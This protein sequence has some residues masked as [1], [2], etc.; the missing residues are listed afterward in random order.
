MNTSWQDIDGWIKLGGIPVVTLFTTAL[1]LYGARRSE[2]KL[3]FG[4]L[5]VAGVLMLLSDLY[6]LVMRLRYEFYHHAMPHNRFFAVLWPVTN[7]CWYLATILGLIGNVLLVIHACGRR[8][9]ER[10]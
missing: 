2:F 8:H 5:A 10:I 3:S 4:L 1:F 6:P 9:A 7:T